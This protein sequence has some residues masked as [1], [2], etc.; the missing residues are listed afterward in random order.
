MHG[1]YELREML[2]G[3]LESYGERGNLN[4][5]ELPMVDTL[6][7]AVKSID[8]ILAMEDSGYSNYSNRR[9][10][11]SY[12]S[13]GSFNSNTS[14]DDGSFRRGGGRSRG[15]YERG[16]SRDDVKGSIISRMQTLMNETANDDDRDIIKRC[17]EQLER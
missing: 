4:R 1:I 17:I 12:N 6:A 14:F 2:F 3:E 10:R 9:G 16:Y 7:H 11:Q 13:N 15:S 5:N 8:T